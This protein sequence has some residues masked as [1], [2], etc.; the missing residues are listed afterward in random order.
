MAFTWAI[1]TYNKLR[2]TWAGASIYSASTENAAYP[3]ENAI[4]GNIESE[5]R[6]TASPAI[7]V[8]DSG[9]ASPALQYLCL[10]F[11]YDMIP[12]SVKIE[13]S[14]AAGSGY[15]SIANN[16]DGTVATT[17]SAIA[18]RSSRILSLT[19]STNFHVGNTIRVSD[20]VLAAKKY[21]IVAVGTGYVEIDQFPLPHANGAAAAL[22]PDSCILAVVGVT[23]T[24]RYVKLTIT[25]ATPHLLEAQGFGISYSFDGNALPLN[26]FPISET[27]ST[28]NIARS[29]S[30]YGIGKMHTGPNYSKYS[31]SIGRIGKNGNAILSWLEKQGR[32]GIL[33][34]NGEYHEVMLSGDIGRL[35]RMSSENE[36]VSYSTQLM[37]EEV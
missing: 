13:T 36:L 25:A 14:A 18:V 27:R 9:V 33:M 15:A 29:L 11:S 30:N 20:G 3:K 19:S 17:L 31:L 23:E 32:F 21:L 5:W 26:P 8:I 24:K 4:D 34:D 12:T 1:C 22:Y 28:G 6:A 35:R 7:L 16:Y 2:S 37:M 10:W